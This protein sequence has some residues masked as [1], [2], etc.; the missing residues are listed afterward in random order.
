M[1]PDIDHVSHHREVFGEFSHLN[2]PA[3]VPFKLASGAANPNP[4]TN[5]SP[6]Y[7]MASAVGFVHLAGR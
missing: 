3:S 6:R 7:G 1:Q 4:N 2:H 5:P